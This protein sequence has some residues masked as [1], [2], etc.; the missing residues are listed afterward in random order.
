MPEKASDELPTPQPYER[1]ANLEV[2]KG[3]HGGANRSSLFELRGKATCAAPKR[4]TQDCPTPQPYCEQGHVDG[5]YEATNH[6]PSSQSLS[7][8]RMRLRC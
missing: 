3:R 7:A 5:A 4:P 8:N 1:E 6:L 2:P